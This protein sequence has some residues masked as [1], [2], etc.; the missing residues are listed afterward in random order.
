MSEMEDGPMF[1]NYEPV[2]EGMDT[3]TEALN[4]KRRKGANQFA[5]HAP[6]QWLRDRIVDLDDSAEIGM[7]LSEMLYERMKKF[8]DMFHPIASDEFNEKLQVFYNVLKTMGWWIVDFHEKLEEPNWNPVEVGVVLSMI[9]I[10]HVGDWVQ[11]CNQ[12]KDPQTEMFMEGAFLNGVPMVQGLTEGLF[13]KEILEIGDRNDRRH[14][15]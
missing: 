1:W 10:K 3:S 9:W 11:E 15:K 8:M 14:G 6:S 4:E 5:E 2:P 7:F 13:A 12:G